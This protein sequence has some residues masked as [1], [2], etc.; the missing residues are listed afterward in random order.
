MISPSRA[1]AGS[2]LARPHFVVVGCARSATT[3]TARLLSEAGCW[4]T[5]EE[6]FG[7]HATGFPG[8]GGAQGDSSWLAA[9][10]LDQLPAGT[11]VFHQVREPLEAVDALVRF[12]IFSNARGGIRQDAVALSRYLRG[13]GVRAVRAGLD[14]RRRRAR[15]H[16][17]RRDYVRFLR[18]RCPEAFLEPNEIARA[19][20]HWIVWN[21]LIERTARSTGSSY[22]RIKVEALDHEVLTS[23]IAMLGG[24]AS[25]ANIEAALDSV[26]ASA[27]R[28][29]GGR[30]VPI[31]RDTLGDALAS[32]FEAAAARYGYDVA[33]P[34]TVSDDR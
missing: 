31:T 1:A 4:C 18:A 3:Y 17:F 14:P 9:P 6:L 26:E 12:E 24:D 2:A 11:V 23:M 27:N 8:W 34:M 10:F 33:V 25:P 30:S 20:R 13:G 28:Q 29:P 16:R 15:G 21:D 7:P 32:S 22:H 5:H 19:A